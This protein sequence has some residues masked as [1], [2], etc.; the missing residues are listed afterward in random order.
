MAKDEPP[1]KQENKPRRREVGGKKWAKKLEEATG[2][3]VTTSPDSAQAVYL[4]LDC[5]GS[6]KGDK[7]NQAKQG[8]LNFAKEAKSKGYLTGLIS[9]SSSAEHLCEPQPKA[10]E[11]ES[12]LEPMAAGGNTNMGSALSLAKRKF[13]E[14]MGV[15][16][17]VIVTDGMPNSRQETSRAAKTLIK[18]GV[19]IITIGTDDAD[20]G[21]LEKI[22]S[23]KD[24][25]KKVKRTQLEKGVQSVAGMLPDQEEGA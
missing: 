23:R 5:S 4:L 25:A 24:L 3:K 17:V 12:Y 19:D 2:K 8:A 21:F 7:L 16:V 14:R 11:L 20:E 22:S 9:F 10:K 18:D 15:R 13:E 1:E 6:M